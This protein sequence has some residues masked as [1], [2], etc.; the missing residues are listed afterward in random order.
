MR[1]LI[2]IAVILLT[3]TSCYKGESA[4][5]VIHNAKIY[6]L[7]GELNV[8]EAVAIRDGKIIEL[9]PNRQILNKY[10]AEQT[11]DAQMRPI[12][13][14][15]ID[16][17]G[18]LYSQAQL[19]LQVDLNHT[20]S[21]KEIIDRLK[22]KEKVNGWI[23][24]RG[25]DHSLWTR[26]TLLNNNFINEA[27]PN[28]PIF[29]K[30]LDGHAALVNQKAIEITGIDSITTI[31]GG[32]IE[33]KDN[34]MTGLL[35]D[36]AIE[37]VTQQIPQPDEATMVNALINAQKNCIK[38][39]ITG[40]HEAGVYAEGRDVFIKATESEDWDLPV[41]LMLFPT[42]ENLDF[43][44]QEGHYEN[45]YLTIRSFKMVADGALGS[46]GACLIHPYND[47]P[48]SHG[49]MTTQL[50]KIKETCQVAKALDY[51]VNTHCIG[52]SA[53]QYVLNTYASELIADNDLRWRIEHAQVVQPKDIALFKKHNIIPSI[54]PTH[55]T[56]DMRWAEERLGKERLQKEGYRAQTF[57]DEGNIIAL[58]TDFPVESYNPF[59]TFYAAISRQNEDGWPANGFL[60]EEKIS[61]LDALKG[62]TVHA[63]MAS[64]QEK[65]TGS[66]EVGKKANLIMLSNDILEI[67]KEEVLKTNIIYT[68]IDGNIVYKGL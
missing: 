47:Q 52:D 19:D 45:K 17:H 29:I 32:L 11:I 37:L 55:A 26:D 21:K 48:V 62:M 20:S 23:Q 22:S 58:G 25:W 34:E 15:F 46:H 63:A 38:Y 36:N 50:E 66:L 51:Q 16:A 43:A 9:G 53:N 6:T 49:I 14:G 27:F 3:F 65:I 41:Y 68:I 24:G 28:T 33:R 1:I 12:F 2:S 31:E 64:F 44:Q 54:Q 10:S 4:D 59:R 57:I 61:R 39:G 8:Y 35:L 5:L 18:H 30:R 42:D 7:D 60:P 67:S 13:P 56:T 40:V